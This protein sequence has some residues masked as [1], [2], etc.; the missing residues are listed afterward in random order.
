MK[1]WNL[2]YIGNVPGKALDPETPYGSLFAKKQ[3]TCLWR[4]DSI[5]Y[6]TGLGIWKC[7]SRFYPKIGDKIKLNEKHYVGKLFKVFSVKGMP[8]GEMLH[9]TLKVLNKKGE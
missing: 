7:P 9:V 6:D 2:G 5:H 8:K 1:T 4:H 3:L